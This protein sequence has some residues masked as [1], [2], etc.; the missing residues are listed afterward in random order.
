MKKYKS[1]KCKHCKRMIKAGDVHSS[2]QEYHKKC[3]KL[4]H[5]E[6]YKR[7]EVKKRVKAY[8]RLYYGKPEII[9]KRR[10]YARKRYI[11][12]CKN[13]K[14]METYLGRARELRRRRELEYVKIPILRPMRW[15]KTNLKEHRIHLKKR[16]F[17][18]SQ[19][20]YCNG[21]S[22]K[23]QKQIPKMMDEIALKLLN[24]DDTTRK[25]DKAN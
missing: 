14:N 10:E 25:I 15:Q 21:M 22:Q 5:K 7:P 6:Y 13:P 12:L 2:K 20:I 23:I 24:E 16:K 8:Q 17:S 19:Y 9:E 4:S 18:A 3:S 11:E 1:K